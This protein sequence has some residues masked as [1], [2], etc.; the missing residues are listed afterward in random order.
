MRITDIRCWLI[1]KDPPAHAY[2]WRTGLQ[3]SG[4]GTPP[5]KKPLG[6]VVRMETDEGIHPTTKEGLAKLGKSAADAI[7]VLAV[8]VATGDLYVDGDLTRMPTTQA[9]AD[10]AYARAGLT[11]AD[12]G[13]AEVHDCFT[14]TEL[15]M[16]EALGFAAPGQAAA[17]VRAGD[18]AIEGTLPIN[19]GGGLVGFGHPVGATGV[20][21]ILEIYRQM[22]G[23]AGTYQIPGRPKFGLT[24][25]MGGDDKTAVVGI[26]ANP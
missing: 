13:V 17:R 15:L 22:K 14:V 19:T 8:E 5:G 21:Q 3:G 4:D 6:A 16:M 18:T 26:F 7:E 23:L 1:E 20:K 10:R 2:R 9:A 25:N 12:I 11:A 24:A